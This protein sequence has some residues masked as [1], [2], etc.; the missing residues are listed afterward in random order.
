MTG[1]VVPGIVRAVICRNEFVVILPDEEEDVV[2]E[3]RPV[4]VVEFDDEED[5]RAVGVDVDETAAGCARGG[6]AA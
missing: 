3:V 6:G 2:D 5:G 4:R 1:C